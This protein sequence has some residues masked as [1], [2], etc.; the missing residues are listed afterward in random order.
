MAK[1][2]NL[3]E[4]RRH[5]EDVGLPAA[6]YRKYLG[7]CANLISQKL[8]PIFEFKHLAHLLG[9]EPFYVGSVIFLPDLHYRTFLIKKRSGG[10]REI[11]APYPA[12]LD[13]QNWIY[14]NILKKVAVNACAHGFVVGRSI[15][16]NASLHLGANQILKMDIRDFFPSIKVN[17]VIHVFKGVGYAHNV[18]VYLAKM[19]CLNDCLPQGSP[20]SPS[21]SNIICKRMDLRLAELSKKWKLKYSRYADDMTFSEETITRNFASI[22]ESIVRDEGFEIQ[23]DKTRFVKS[24]RKIVTGISISGEKLSL[25]K[26]YKRKIRQNVYFIIKFGIVSHMG[27]RKIRDPFH[28]DRVFGKL[29]FWRWVE[30][31][32]EFPKR[33]IPAMKEI[34]KE[35]GYRETDFGRDVE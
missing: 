14:S 34:L 3:P 27:K 24:G 4:W 32:A 20:T 16:T 7:Y 21:L 15:L 18:S 23:S 26:G 10:S 29:S 17:R 6:I 33:M 5:Y 8:P 31:Q 2:V 22:V 25:P 9:K 11:S 1:L 28:I 30:P 12:L 13:C 35:Y 19:C